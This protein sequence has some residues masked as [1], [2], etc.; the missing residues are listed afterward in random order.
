[1][2]LSR[3]PA[4]RALILHS[5]FAEDKKDTL[6]TAVADTGFACACIRLE[7]FS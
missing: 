5:V 4:K 6:Q 3:L 2:P 1:M 7:F